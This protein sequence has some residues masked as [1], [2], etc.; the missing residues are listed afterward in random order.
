MLPPQINVKNVIPVSDV[1]IR[2]PNSV[3]TY[4]F[5]TDHVFTSNCWKDKNTEKETEN[6]KQTSK[7][8]DNFNI[9]KHQNPNH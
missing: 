2:P 8:D 1:G 3:L 6:G 4:K 7:S 9:N 5:Y